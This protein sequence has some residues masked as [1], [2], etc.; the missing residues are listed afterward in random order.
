MLFRSTI[1]AAA[2]AH[3]TEHIAFK[4]RQEIEKQLGFELPPEKDD[5]PE[6]IEYNLSSLVSQAAGQL[7]QKDQAEQQQQQIQQQMQDPVIQMQQQDLLIRQA[8]V[9][10]KAAKDQA[11]NQYKQLREI[12]ALKKEQMRLEVQEKIAGA[13][14]GAK[15]G[16]TKEKIASQEKTDG[17]RIGIDIAKLY[18]GM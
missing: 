9:Q 15:V 13:Q 10:R 5:L 7:L 14:I 4:Y 8:E 16:E 11:D 18:K 2:T 17:T 1:A 12:I 3:V 6:D